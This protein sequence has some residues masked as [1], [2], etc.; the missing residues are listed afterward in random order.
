MKWNDGPLPTE[1]TSKERDMP[2]LVLGT[3]NDKKRRELESLLKIESLE[4]LTLTSFPHAPEIDETGTTFL[5]N[6]TLKATILARSLGEW[7][8]GEDSGLCVDALGGSPGIYSA[9]YAGIPCDDEKNNDR[10]LQELES[11]G[12]QGR[13]AHYV[14]VSVIASPDGAVVATSE[15]ICRGTIARERRGSGGFGYDPLFLWPAEGKTFGELPAEFK[16]RVSHRAE[17]IRQLRPKILRLLDSG[18]WGSA[19]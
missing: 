14:C 3:R 16:H 8:M 10:L 5:E 19:G 17:S 12:D 13:G 9:R 2:R 15:G 6:A 11:V 7:V 4:L 18:I 1:I